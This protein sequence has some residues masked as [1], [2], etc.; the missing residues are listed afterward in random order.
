[1]GENLRSGPLCGQPRSGMAAGRI[2]AQRHKDRK[3]LR[4]DDPLLQTRSCERGY[5]RRSGCA[6]S[7]PLVPSPAFLRTRLRTDRRAKRANKLSIA[8]DLLPRRASFAPALLCGFV[9]SCETSSTQRKHGDVSHGGMKASG[10]KFTAGFSLRATAVV[11]GGGRILAQRHKGHKGSA[12]SDS[13]PAFLRMQ[14][15]TDRR[16]KRA[17]QLSTL[18]LQLS[19]CAKRPE[20]PRLACACLPPP[21]AIPAAARPWCV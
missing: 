4:A 5:E 18:N 17:D 16:A 14:L 2:L 12:P 20:S 19:T 1:M 3:G 8:F 15:R 10:E 11:N 21:R 7:A 13:S 9:P 6:G